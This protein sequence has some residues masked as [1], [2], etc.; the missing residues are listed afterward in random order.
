[1][2]TIIQTIA[3]FPIA[4][5]YALRPTT[6]DSDANAFVNRIDDLDDE[7]NP[8]ASQ[9]NAVAAEVNGARN[10][11]VA[12]ATIAT[13]QA[14]LALQRANAA[15]SSAASATGAAAISGT[16]I[17][18]ITPAL[19]L[20]TWTYVETGKLPF[21]G[22]RMRAVSRA[23][24]ATNYALGYVS[25][26]NSGTRALTLFIDQITEFAAVAA[27]WNLVLEGQPGIAGPQAEVLMPFR[28]V[29]ANDNLINEDNGKHIDCGSLITLTAGALLYPGWAAIINAQSFPVQINAQF[30][31]GTN[32]RTLQPRTS[33]MLSFNGTAY[34]LARMGAQLPIS[35]LVE[36]SQ[37]ITAPFGVIG[38]KATI[39]GGGSGAHNR[40]GIGAV[41]GSGG[42]TAIKTFAI[43]AGQSVNC[44]VGAGGISNPTAQQ[45][46]NIAGGQSSVTV[47][48][49]AV[50]AG[51]G[52]VGD[53][54]YRPTGGN[55]LNGDINLSGGNG[56][57]GNVAGGSYWAA[58]GNFYDGYGKYYGAGGQ[59]R[60]FDNVYEKGAKGIVFLEW[61]MG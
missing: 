24:P 49:V 19:G 43:S 59:F 48:G 33:G 29:N 12:Q 11:A 3:V 38:V 36:I 5:D 2:A 16:S 21:V 23:A 10:T 41:S 61:I 45:Y 34:R 1:M 46:W 6:F 13:D 44:L 50:T 55:A 7:L 52:D 35:Q 15:A 14:T 28:I 47:N 20:Q 18:S 26:F 4:P 37:N 60:P 22:M 53:N 32:S 58:G 31:D 25:A 30:I 27:D 17:T 57:V 56:N 42:A 39:T 54:D 51:G 8:F 40:I 9:A